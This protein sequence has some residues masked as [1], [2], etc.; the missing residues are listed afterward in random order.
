MKREESK[1]GSSG[2]GAAAAAPGMASAEV[3]RG[4]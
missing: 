2:T 3:E 1:L 4:P